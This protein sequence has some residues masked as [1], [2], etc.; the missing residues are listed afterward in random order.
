MTTTNGLKSEMIGGE[1]WVECSC[2]AGEYL[3]KPLQHRR[4][5]RTRAQWSDVSAVGAPAASVDA[6]NETAIEIRRTSLR[7]DADVLGLVR[8]KRLSVNDAMNT[9]D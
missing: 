1:R 4:S 8:T 6:R 7:K 2:G 5:C 9:D 3:P